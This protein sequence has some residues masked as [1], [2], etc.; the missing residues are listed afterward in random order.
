MGY[1]NTDSHGIRPLNRCLEVRTLCA[2]A[3]LA[4]C[5]MGI[6]AL[7]GAVF[8][9]KQWSHRSAAPWRLI[10]LNETMALY[11]NPDSGITPH[12]QVSSIRRFSTVLLAVN[13]VLTVTNESIGFIHACSLRWSLHRSGRL[14]FNTNLRLFTYLGWF[15]VNGVLG[16]AISAISTIFI[17][18]ASSLMFV[19]TQ[20]SGE[21][22]TFEGDSYP[23]A[24]LAANPL[25]IVCLAFG[26]IGQALIGLWSL[27]TAIPT[28]SLSPVDTVQAAQQAKVVGGDRDDQ[29]VAV[30]ET[31]T[32]TDTGPADARR[33][34]I[35]RVH[36]LVPWTIGLLW[37][38][39]VVSA[40]CCV[41]LYHAAMQPALGPYGLEYLHP[42]NDDWSM[43][44][45]EIVPVH[46]NWSILPVSVVEYTD[47]ISETDLSGPRPILHMS[48]ILFIFHERLSKGFTAASID[49]AIVIVTQSFIT[50]ALHIVELPSSLHRDEVTWR[51]ATRGSVPRISS[52]DPLLAAWRHPPTVLLFAAKVFIHWVYGLSFGSLV[53]GNPSGLLSIPLEL[54]PVQLI[55]MTISLAMVAAGITAL[56]VWPPKCQQP[57][58]CGCLR[59]VANW[60]D[61]HATAGRRHQDER[62]SVAQGETCLE[63]HGESSSPRPLT[64]Q[65]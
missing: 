25:A 29:G 36:P 10:S 1:Q 63:L 32:G 22:E 60:M 45:S 26:L 44:P 58:T 48:P 40:C 56:S 27:R 20:D 47:T 41:A 9:W 62:D 35:F 53:Q 24:T 23:A 17:Y 15:E 11:D 59:A 42:N 13:V 5:L 6:T 50:L 43:F 4:N 7:G 3:I 39:V 18:A 37:V 14:K 34:S 16:N 30:A 19:P 54:R 2:L 21:S 33:P 64:C 51:R 65:P 57:V 61:Q 38:L 31:S 12:F 28:W 46:D 55:Y 8:V 49:L 52:Y